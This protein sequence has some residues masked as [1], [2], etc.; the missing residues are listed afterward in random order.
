MEDSEYADQP[1]TK[2][3]EAELLDNLQ[4]VSPMDGQYLVRRE[5]WAKRLLKTG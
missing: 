3:C 4:R 5:L 1:E 2:I